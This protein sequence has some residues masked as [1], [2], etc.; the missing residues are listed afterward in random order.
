MSSSC[1][2]LA[3]FQF[4]SICYS[5]LLQQFSSEQFNFISCIAS[6]TKQIPMVFHAFF[7]TMKYSCNASSIKTKKL[8]KLKHSELLLFLTPFDCLLSNAF[9]V[10]W[11][12]YICRVEAFTAENVTVCFCRSHRTNI[13]HIS[14]IWSVRGSVSD[15]IKQF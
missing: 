12:A 6:K 14:L 8:F 3:H 4:C 11:D 1:V 10:G 15:C 7:Q 9:C 13:F 5:F 2:T